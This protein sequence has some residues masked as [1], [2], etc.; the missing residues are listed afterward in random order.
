MMQAHCLNASRL[1]DHCLKE[2]PR[3][4]DQSRAHLFE[5][6]PSFFMRECLDELLFGRRQDTLQ[7][8]DDEIA[9]QMGVD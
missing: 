3:R 8:N 4:F 7:T 5:Q 6:V 2:W 9:D 1:D